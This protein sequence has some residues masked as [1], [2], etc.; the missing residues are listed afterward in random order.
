MVLDRT[1]GRLDLRKLFAL[2]PVTCV[3]FIVF[4]KCDIVSAARETF[5]EYGVLFI[6][7]FLNL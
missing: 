6:N 4:H 7:G 5:E 1:Y 2:G 3:I